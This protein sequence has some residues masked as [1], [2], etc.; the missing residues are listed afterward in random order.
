[1][2]TGLDSVAQRPPQLGRLS[3]VA[4]P[5]TLLVHTETEC[6]FGG[7]PSRTQI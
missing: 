6:A 3:E 2:Q 4:E 7:E 5:A 1:M